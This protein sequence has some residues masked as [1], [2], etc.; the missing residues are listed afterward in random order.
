MKGTCLNIRHSRGRT[1]CQKAMSK[2]ITHPLLV[3]PSSATRGL[4]GVLPNQIAA[5]YMRRPVQVRMSNVKTRP[6]M[7]RDSVRSPYW[8]IV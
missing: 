1:R 3:G 7:F 6:L 8:S 5:A 4:I 2:V